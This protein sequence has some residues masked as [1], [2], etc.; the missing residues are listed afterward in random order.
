MLIDMS[1]KQRAVSFIDVLTGLTEMPRDAL[2]S[3]ATPQAATDGD[4]EETYVIGSAHGSRM[5]LRRCKSAV[6]RRASMRPSDHELFTWGRPAP[7]PQRSTDKVVNSDVRT[8]DA[9][10]STPGFGE[11]LQPPPA[12]RPPMTPR[13]SRGGGTVI[14]TPRAKLVAPAGRAASPSPS[15]ASSR[16]R[17][18]SPGLNHDL[19]SWPGEHVAMREA[20]PISV[21]TPRTRRTMEKLNARNEHG[22]DTTP[23]AGATTHIAA[24][25]HAPYRFLIDPQATAAVPLHEQQGNFGRRHS[26]G[27]TDIISRTKPQHGMQRA[28]HGDILG[29]RQHAA[30]VPSPRAARHNGDILGWT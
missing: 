14:L 1:A 19:L 2:V 21:H 13:S 29:W 25:L 22:L 28:A 8:A 24:S 20:S 12:A 23:V 5:A 4:R 10:P 7:S 16:R 30:G 18:V 15:V 17:S 27:T 9:A 3:P 6:D 11:P 26:I